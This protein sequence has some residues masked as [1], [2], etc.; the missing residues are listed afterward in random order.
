M[1]IYQHRG[2]RIA[3]VRA[4]AGEPVVL[5]H[6]GG[7]SHAIWRDV[8]PRL[9]SRH[10][11]FALDLLGYGASSR[12][13]DGYTLDHY[14]EILEGFLTTLRLAPAALVGNC[15]GSAM[16]LALAIARPQLVSALVLVNPLTRATLLAGSLGMPLPSPVIT[17]LRHM[18]VPRAIAR[19]FI[20]LQLGSLGRARR[21]DRREDLCACYD[22]PGQMRSLLGVREDLDSYRALDT[23]SPGP[24]FPPTTIIWGLENRVLPASAGRR[25]VETLRPARQEWLPGCGHL[26]MVE[27]PERVASIIAEAIEVGASAHGSVAP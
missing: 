17:V 16:S 10:E 3:F 1:E 9:A 19:N 4:G 24:A 14:V 18:R 8:I 21:L 25:L 11:V 27:A 20:R 13:A 26:P 23:F 5:L 6:N 2:L 22:S 7:M 15:M 12:P